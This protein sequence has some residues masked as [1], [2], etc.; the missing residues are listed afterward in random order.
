MWGMGGEK[1]LTACINPYNQP[2]HTTD[3]FI[4]KESEFY[5]ETYDIL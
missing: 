2:I 5:F 1:I 4:K 3:I